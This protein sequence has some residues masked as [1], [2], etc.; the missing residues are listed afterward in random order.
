[1]LSVTSAQTNRGRLISG[2]LAGAMT[3][4]GTVAGCVSSA[5]SQND[6]VKYSVSNYVT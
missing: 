1:M 2:Y 5:T 4:L 6:S 3:S